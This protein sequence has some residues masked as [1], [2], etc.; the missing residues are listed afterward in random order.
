MI[1][2]LISLIGISG[3]LALCFYVDM[4]ERLA[5]AEVR[6]EFVRDSILV[7]R[8]SFPVNGAQAFIQAIRATQQNEPVIARI[9]DPAESLNVF[10]NKLVVTFRV[11]TAHL[12]FNGVESKMNFIPVQGLAEDLSLMTNAELIEHEKTKGD[13]AAQAQAQAGAREATGL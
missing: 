10:L 13:E 12:N 2:F 5:E 9:E 8:R 3:I 1:E 4:H 6:L 7:L 11:R